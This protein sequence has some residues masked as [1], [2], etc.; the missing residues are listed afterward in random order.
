MNWLQSLL[1]EQD[2]QSIINK[3]EEDGVFF[4]M[5]KAIEHFNFLSEEKERLYAEIR[6]HLKYTVKPGNPINKPFKMNGQHTAAL[7]NYAFD[8]SP[9]TYSAIDMVY[10][11]SGPFSRVWFKEPS[12]TSH[13]ELK[14]QLSELGWKPDTWNYK[15]DSRGKVMYDN[16]RNPIKSSPKLTESSYKS[17]SVGIGPSLVK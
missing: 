3:Q 13:N 14:N 12:L 4:D 6:P 1:L 8:I 10:S 11:V 17:L 16:H 7:E 2:I 9:N 15:K 5:P